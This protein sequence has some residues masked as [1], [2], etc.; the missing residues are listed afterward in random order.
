MSRIL[1]VYATTDG[2]TRRISERI[3]ERIGASGYT[4][5]LQS[6]ADATDPAAHDAVIAGAS[7]R[8][9]KHSP[10]MREF[11]NRH[12]GALEGRPTAFFSVN[13][14]ARKPD[15]RTV[16]SNESVRKFVE[17]LNFKPT[18]IEIFPGKLDY[19]RYKFF[20]RLMIRLI[21]KMTGGPTD[22]K[23]VVD[24]TN[25]DEVDRFADS[26]VKLIH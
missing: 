6:V 25:W 24:Y 7:V 8:Y 3:A 16:E 11:L 20:E 21:M 13:L 15:R 4:A 10:A 5:T 12:A 19:P 23:A 18:R 17:S 2:H 14:V 26:M 1:I 22:G 9:G